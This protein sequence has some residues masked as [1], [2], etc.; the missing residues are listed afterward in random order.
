MTKEFD[1]KHLVIR[2]Y[3]ESSFKYL[4]YSRISIYDND[5]KTRTR[6]LQKFYGVRELRK[7]QKL[8]YKSCRGII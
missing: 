7:T 8:R 3:K 5:F 6:V 1:W 4:K 2:L